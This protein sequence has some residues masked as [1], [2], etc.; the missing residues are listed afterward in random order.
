[1][2]RTLP[3]NRAV[4]RIP[5]NELQMR[6]F[7]S[8]TLLTLRAAVRYRLVVVMAILLLVAVAVL[9]AIIKHD[10]TAE[11]FIQIVLTYTLSVATAL[12]GFVT[13]WLACGTLAREVEDCRIQLV[14]VKPVSRWQ[15][16]LGKWTGLMALNAL[17]L[18]GAGFVIYALVLWKAHG[19]PEPEQEKLQREVLVARDAVTEPEPDLEPLVQNAFQEARERAEVDPADLGILYH[20]VEE[21]VKRE[22][23][24]VR[25]DHFRRWKLQFSQRQKEKLRNQPLYVR[26][27]FRTPTLVEL[28]EDPNTY[29]TVWKVGDPDN[30]N[31]ARAIMKLAPGAYHEFKVPPNLINEDGILIVDMENRSNSPFYIFLED[32]LEVL[33]DAGGFALNFV[34]GVGIIFCWLGLLAAIGMC[35]A[36]FLSFPVAAFLALGVLIVGFSTGTLSGA[37]KE[38]SVLGID[39]NRT[40]KSRSPVL[41]RILLP[42]FKVIIGVVHLVKEFSPIDSLSSGRKIP[43]GELAS[44]A[45][46]IIGLMG[47]ILAVIGITTFTRRELATA[48]NNT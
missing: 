33:Y 9:P 15:V 46:Q 14:V 17:L 26:V 41:D 44:A 19:L 31:R 16:W 25:P 8:I 36:S 37:V 38:G 29:Q 48:G 40:M 35:A 43:W 28:K 32:P 2:T 6:A 30:P 1:M 3:T 24:L 42:T 22:Y 18:A 12:L 23:Q 7:L 39:Y 20:Q 47:G 27:K 34:R 21:A 5:S 11:G 4:G 10:Q 13:L 45:F